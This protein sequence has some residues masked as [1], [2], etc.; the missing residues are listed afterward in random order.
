MS[1][2]NTRPN[3]RFYAWVDWHNTVFACLSFDA[4]AQIPL[5]RLH[6]LRADGQQLAD[7]QTGIDYDEDAI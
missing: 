2:I 5:I 7:A 4:A 6:I 1:P 3:E